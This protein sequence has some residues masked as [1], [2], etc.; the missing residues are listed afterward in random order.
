MSSQSAI[1][2]IGIGLSL[3]FT[4]VGIALIAYGA[5]MRVSPIYARSGP[6]LFPWLVGGLTA[7]IGIA[8]LVSA[9]RNEL[10]APS[11]P[12]GH[13]ASG[14]I[15]ALGLPVQILTIQ[16]LGWIPTAAIVFVCG[17]QALRRGRLMTDILIGLAIGLITYFF[18]S[19]ILG[20][21]LPLGSLFG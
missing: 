20:L 3:V 12:K 7:A 2:L 5:T 19:H 17:A 10:L 15:M 14:M 6:Q 4:A 1:R 9:L 21:R 18:F 8:A 16:W 13:L 11:M